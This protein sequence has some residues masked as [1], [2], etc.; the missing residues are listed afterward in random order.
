MKFKIEQSSEK[1]NS[2]GGMALVGALLDKSGLNETLD[3]I[4]T[5]KGRPVYSNSLI[6]RSYFGLLCQG[7]TAFDDLNI[8]KNNEFYADSL[9][10]K[11]LASIER[12]RQRLDEGAGLFD[13]S[14]RK[15]NLA[16]LSNQQ[17][18]R[19]KTQLG[20]YIPWDCDVSPMD[21]SRTK[22]QN[23]SRTYKDYDGYAP[24][25]GYL[26]GEGFMLDC[27]LRPGKQHCQSGTVEFLKRGLGFIEE[28][29]LKGEVLLRLDSGNDSAENLELIQGQCNFIIK[30]NLRKE[31]R[32]Q[33]LKTAM[34]LGKKSEP[35]L[36]KTVY[37]G[38]LYSKQ[39]ANENCSSVPVAF[40]V[41]VR[42]IDK[43]GNYLLFPQLK[44]DTY[45]TNLCEDAEEIIKL[46]HDHGTSEQF[47][48]ELKSDMDVERLPSSNFGTN[49]LVLLL[50]M[51]AFNCLRTIGQLMIEL[52]EF[53]PVKLTVKRRRIKSVIRDIILTACKYVRRS[54][55]NY[56]K[57][58]KCNPWFL[59]Y[60]SLYQRLVA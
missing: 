25:F 32:E 42:E 16:L 14:I 20:S 50:S 3:A 36:G 5:G 17:F 39:P 58:G 21:N 22:K 19:V 30:R 24:M 60:K 38:V 34:D 15:V 37:K 54:N 4:Q 33:W 53:S 57:L 48:S 28:L 2:A 7:R 10:I 29:G 11:G 35:R 47:H 27:E 8:F 45:W 31:V 55:Q 59:M 6:V 26:G 40:E 1:I 18:S 52:K 23:V 12:I 9:N 56:I 41:T 13:S 49:G 44:V 51:L 43:A 46:Y